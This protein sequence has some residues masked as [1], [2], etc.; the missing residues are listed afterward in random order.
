VEKF[1]DD[2]VKA[3]EGAAAINDSPTADN[4]MRILLLFIMFPNSM[5]VEWNPLHS[6]LSKL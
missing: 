1:P 6:F 5:R 4:G 2:H 3:I